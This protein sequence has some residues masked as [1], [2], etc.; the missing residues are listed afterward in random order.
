MHCGGACSQIVW[1]SVAEVDELILN[2]LRDLR[3]FDHR[4]NGVLGS[5]DGINIATVDGGFLDIRR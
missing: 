1:I 2:R 3:A 5:E 4:I